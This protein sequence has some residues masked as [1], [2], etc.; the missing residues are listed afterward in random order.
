MR[1]LIVA[2]I[3]CGGVQPQPV[4]GLAEPQPARLCIRKVMCC[5][6]SP[7]FGIVCE[8]CCDPSPP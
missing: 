5:W 4:K 3:A 2:L 6:P 7:A 1:L 8:L